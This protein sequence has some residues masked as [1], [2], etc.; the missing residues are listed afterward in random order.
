MTSAEV[1]AELGWDNLEAVGKTRGDDVLGTLEVY[2]A[3]F[4][5]N[6]ALIARNT[7]GDRVT[8]LLTEDEVRK[9]QEHLS[10]APTPS[11]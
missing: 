10:C 7:R 2:R 1:F 5:R 8:I 6:L 4:G 3:P 9:L 11:I